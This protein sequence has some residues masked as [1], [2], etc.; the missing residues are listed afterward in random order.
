MTDL[1]RNDLRNLFKQTHTAHA[2]LLIQ[3]GLTKWEDGDKPTKKSLVQKISHVQA[4]GLYLLAFKRWLAH[5]YETSEN[6]H[7]AT[8]SAKVDGRLMT[9][10]PLGGTLETGVTTHHTYGMPMIAGSSVKGAVRSYAEFLF[11]QRNA[12]ASIDYLEEIDSKGKVTK[13]YQFS[14]DK[15]AILDVLFGADDDDNPNAGYLIWHD[16][17]WIPPTTSDFKLSTG[18][19]N[20]PFVDEV[21]TVHHQDYYNGKLTE[22]LDMENPLPNQQVAVQ[23]SFYFVIEGVYAWVQY[24]KKLLEAT[25]QQQGLGAKGGAGYGYFVEDKDLITALQKIYTKIN[26][27]GDG[28]PIKDAIQFL[29]EEELVTNLSKGSSKFF[30]ALN[31]DKDSVDDRIKVVTAVLEFH[32]AI[33]DKWSDAQKGSNPEKALKFVNNNR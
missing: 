24:A 26:S 1:M 31:L 27:K 9:G 4:D 21:M 18:E 2:G 15:Q 19:Q 7:F 14:D 20:K 33:V 28:D 29:S 32:Q 10:L 12:D 22:A 3:R 23:G 13:L 16:A 25:L 11:A 30:K 8:I 6:P 5:S 17:W